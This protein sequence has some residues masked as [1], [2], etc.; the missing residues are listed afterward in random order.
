[1]NNKFFALPQEKRER[2]ISAAQEVFAKN[3]YKRAVT[4]EIAARGGISKGLLFHYF[5][6]KKGLYLYLYQHSLDFVHRQMYALAPL[7]ETDFFDLLIHAHA[8]KLSVMKTYPFLFSFLMQA[9]GE[10]EEA[11]LG[12][13]WQSNDAVFARSARRI[14]EQ[15]DWSKFKEGI[16]PKQVLNLV[17]WSAEGFLRL[18]KEVNTRNIEALGNQYLECL[19]LLKQNLYKEEYL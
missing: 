6:N 8:V 11:I 5:E 1:M 7:D 12:S 4:D 16:D 19:T 9:R 15:T 10:Q 3:T 2:I 13:V 18:Q 14:I 17:L